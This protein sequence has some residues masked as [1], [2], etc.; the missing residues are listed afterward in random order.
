M[1]KSVVYPT[2][3]WLLLILFLSFL[4]PCFCQDSTATNAFL[5]GLK[6]VQGTRA[7][8]Y[9]PVPFKVK[10][11]ELIDNRPDT[12]LI[13]FYKNA[14]EQ[15]Y[16]LALNRQETLQQLFDSL[17]TGG[18]SDA[19]IKIVLNHLFITNP[20]VYRK[21]LVG[22]LFP[23]IIS[24]NAKVYIQQDGYWQ[25]LFKADTIIFV[26]SNIEN[27]YRDLFYE[28]GLYLSRKLQQNISTNSFVNHPKLSNRVIDSINRPV[29]ARPLPISDTT[30][31]FATFDDF[32][33]GHLTKVDL[34]LSEVQNG[35]Y[36]AYEKGKNDE[37]GL[38]RNVWGLVK[39]GQTYIMRYS[40]LM[41][42]VKIDNAYYWKEVFGGRYRGVMI[43]FNS[44]FNKAV[45]STG[46][47]KKNT[48]IKYFFKPSMLNMQN[49]GNY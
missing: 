28:A 41:P 29:V 11:V 43:P 7:C 2:L 3:K 5:K 10:S 23:C 19:K 39:N 22:K 33:N 40:M 42:L 49:G 13:G 17:L 34:T 36:F 46:A 25:G 27:N 8:I 32:L 12:T 21:M 18:P 31:F 44:D 38:I 48:S 20:P 45:D 35:L 24:I 30:G 6:G 1:I 15:D 26:G 16:Y 47:P 37:G 4:T 9:Y 14:M